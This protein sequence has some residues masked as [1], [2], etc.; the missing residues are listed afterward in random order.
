MLNAPYPR[1]NGET[2]GCAGPYSPKDLITITSATS[3]APVSINAAN[4]AMC[5]LPRNCG[6]TVAQFVALNERE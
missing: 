5:T 6:R 2:T 3:T 4:T 1:V